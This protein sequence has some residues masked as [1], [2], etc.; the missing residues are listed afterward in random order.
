M[1]VGCEFSVWKLTTCIK[2]STIHNF[3]LYC[4]KFQRSNKV[5]LYHI[6]VTVSFSQAEYDATNGT[7]NIVLFLSQPLD[8]PLDTQPLTVNVSFVS[9]AEESGKGN[10]AYI[11]M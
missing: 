11:N 5:S 7:A 1:I 6:V 2:I 10:S 3:D 8:T 4:T 9:D